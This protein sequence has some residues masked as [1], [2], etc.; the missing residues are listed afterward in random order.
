MYEQMDMCYKPNFHFT[1]K[2]LTLSASF[3]IHFLK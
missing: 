3:V 1:A 2:E